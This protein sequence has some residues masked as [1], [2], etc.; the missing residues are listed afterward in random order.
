MSVHAVN[1]N[2][3]PDNLTPS[4]I[5][6][7]AVPRIPLPDCSSLPP[8]KKTRFRAMKIARQEME[9]ITAQRPVASALKHRHSLRPHPFFKFGEKVRIWREE[10]NKFVG[11]YTVHAY[12][13]EKTVYVMT[14]KIRPFSVSKIRLIPPS[15]DE[16][17]VQITPSPIS[18]QEHVA[19]NESPDSL[20]ENPSRRLPWISS[21]FPDVPQKFGSFISSSSPLYRTVIDAFLASPISHS[22]FQSFLKREAP[23]VYVTVMVKNKHDSR[24]NEAKIEE[25]NKVVQLGTYEIVPETDYV[26]RGTVPES[27]FVLTIKNHG[28]ESEYFKARLVILGHLDPDKPRVV[29][30]APIVLKSSIRLLLTIISSYR[31]PVWS[32]DITLA[33]F[34]SKEILKRDV[35]V[36]PPE[37]ENVLQQIGA[38]AGSILKAVKPQYGLAESPGYW[39]QTFRD[40]HI[41]DLQMHP[42]I[43]DPC[44]FFK[45][46]PSGLGGV[47]VT[48]VDDTCGGGS[49]EFSLL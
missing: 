16:N 39:R 25:I 13:N 47:Q 11:L 10:Q 9:T 4:I 41:T 17:Q 6:Y 38:P 20:A 35:Y 3:G 32:R 28:E 2:A 33:F 18:L 7:G 21:E 40:W 36:R 26:S 8:D 27:R 46:G 43:L 12:D 14:D 24:F 34:Q 37:G 15:A 48:Q 23:S 45:S 44:F 42:T 22:T 31:F 29:S 30:E 49:S 19:N 1:N 5:V